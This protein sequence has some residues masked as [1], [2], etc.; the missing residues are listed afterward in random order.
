MQL[1][2]RSIIIRIDED[3]LTATVDG[4]L[5]GMSVERGT[6]YG[7]N[8][9]GTRVWELLAEPRSLKQLCAELEAEFDVD[10]ATCR[11]AVE[12]HLA[13]MQS[14]GLIAVK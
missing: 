12:S 2:D 6:C 13:E 10:A 1:T 4:E 5:L 3:L 14:A 9:V 7:L 11:H 8:G